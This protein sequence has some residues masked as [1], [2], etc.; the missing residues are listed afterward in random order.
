MSRH[1]RGGGPAR[2]TAPPDDELDGFGAVVWVVIA[3]AV[4]AILGGAV[5]ASLLPL[6]RFT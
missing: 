4:A 1:V 3:L 5:L 2:R 6:D